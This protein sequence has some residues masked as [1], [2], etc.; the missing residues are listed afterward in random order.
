MG[1]CL[2]RVVDEP[3]M[4]MGAMTGSKI[5]L[6]LSC[7]LLLTGAPSTFAGDKDVASKPI[8]PEKA[9]QA[10][11]QDVSQSSHRRLEDA[12]TAALLAPS[13]QGSSLVVMSPVNTIRFSLQQ[14]NGVKEVMLID[15]KTREVT[16]RWTIDGA[17]NAAALAE[18]SETVL[19]DM[20]LSKAKS[21][22]NKHLGIKLNPDLK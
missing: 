17:T 14:A 7:A 19:L 4:R 12:V 2:S 15:A 6:L 1:E 3:E 8:A 10:V 16:R 21:L 20:G 9:K 22:S 5:G 18:I 13:P 11:T